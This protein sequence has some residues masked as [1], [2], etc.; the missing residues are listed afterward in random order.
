M[1]SIDVTHPNGSEAGVPEC[2]P[3]TVTGE[4]SATTIET[5]PPRPR[6]RRGL[7]ISVVSMVVIAAVAVAF[8]LQSGQRGGQLQSSRQR[9]TVL[10][11][12][13]GTT[14]RSLRDANSQ[15]D[16][17]KQQ[18]A[19]TQK[20]GLDLSAKNKTLMTCLSDI[21]DGDIA[22]QANNKQALAAADQRAA[23]DCEK[24]DILLGPPASPA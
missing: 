3:V 23:F 1:A 10:A 8:G 7:A 17:Y 9:T 14:Q 13:L 19:D 5:G 21:R 12:Q 16:A 11:R 2:I 15:R 4:A 22:N 20:A 24:A 6:K 18:L